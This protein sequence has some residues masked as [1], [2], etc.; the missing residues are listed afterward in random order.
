MKELI[1]ERRRIADLSHDPANARKHNPRNIDAIKASLRTFG[2]QKP[3]VVTPANVVL[4]GNGTLEAA[5]DIGWD[6]INVVVSD[7][8]G[9]EQRAFA[10]ADN[11]TAELA[12]W[13]EDVLTALLSSIQDEDETLAM[14]V[15]FTED[16]I[17]GLLDGLGLDGQGS[18]LAD[19][20]KLVV[21]S[22]VYKPTGVKPPIEALYDITKT[23]A[24]LQEINA[25]EIDSDA[26]AFLIAA[27]H[28]HT[29]FNYAQIAEWY[30]HSS[31]VVQRL[32]ERS[33]LIIVD[34]NQAIE[35]G[36]VR[37]CERLRQLAGLTQAAEATPE[38]E[39]EQGE[40]D[41]MEVAE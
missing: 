9:A 14:A 30:C 10:I 7:L 3:I 27:A 13:D 29:R 31:P 11:R 36:F 35:S 2:Q 22:P 20:P 16:E 39:D 33:A 6:E 4:A 18:G 17:K 15:G 38:V 41:A 40:V 8:S 1:I 5:R 25:T 23:R 26:K 19:R 12:E 28:R 34:F 21:E 24:L 37:V 32:M